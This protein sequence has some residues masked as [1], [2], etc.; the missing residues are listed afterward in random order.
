[1]LDLPPFLLTA[2]YPYMSCPSTTFL[3]ALSV[4][5]SESAF[6]PSHNASVLLTTHFSSSPFS[7]S[8]TASSN[9]FAL[10]APVITPSPIQCRMILYPVTHPTLRGY[11]PAHVGTGILPINGIL[12]TVNFSFIFYYK[13]L[14]HFKLLFTRC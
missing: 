4:S 13:V 1:V 2:S 5:I 3:K 8:P 10:L 7:T 9:C 11:E 6:T 12:K 14:Y